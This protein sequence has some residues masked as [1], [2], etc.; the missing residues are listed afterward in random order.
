MKRFALTTLRDFGMG[1]TM[2]EEIMIEECR[3]LVKEFEQFEG[4][5]V[6][7]ATSYTQHHFQ[8]GS[9]SL[10]E[11]GEHLTELQVNPKND[12]FVIYCIH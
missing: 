11:M 3:Y 2:S 10:T 4:N 7:P 1:K 12:E 6:R 5:F 9:L 8:T